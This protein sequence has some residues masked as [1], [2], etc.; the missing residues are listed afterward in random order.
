MPE[1][2]GSRRWGVTR[3]DVARRAGVSTAVVSYV[4][5]GGPRAVSADKRAR[6]LRAV[7]DLGYS[8]DAVAAALSSRHSRALGL[9]LPDASNP[10]FA[11][12]ARRIEDAAFARGYIVLIGNSAEDRD[13]EARHLAAF[14]SHRVDG[15][16]ACVADVDAPVPSGLAE[17]LDRVV[18]LDRVPR[19]WPGRAV[20]VDNR[21]GGALAAQRLRSRGCRRTAIVAGPAGFA[22]VADRVGGF[23]TSAGGAAEVDV[24]AAASFGFESGRDAMARLLERVRLDGVF[25]C[26][27]ALAIG[28]LAALAERGRRV[29]DD[30]A[31]IGFDD[32][33][34]ARVTNPP[35]TTIAQPLDDLAEHALTSLLVPGVPGTVLLP[36]RL[37]ARASA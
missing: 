31:V 20:A 8:R 1:P 36:P 12:L 21:A 26:S 34:Q 9:L 16:V 35:L 18:L 22:H 29:P 33:P 5:N 10:F 14:F 4:L 25:C 19:D 27:D 17:R 6:V 2:S 3:D 37:V 23:L 15:V 7:T 24:E 13:R 28:A 11:D 30:V 32:V